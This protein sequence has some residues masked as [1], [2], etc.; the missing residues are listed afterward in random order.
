MRSA[1][2]LKHMRHLFSE[3]V[4]TTGAGDCFVGASLSWIFNHKLCLG[5]Y[6]S[7]ELTDLLI[8]GNTVASLSIQKHG[9]I[10]AMPSL[11]EISAFQAE[12]LN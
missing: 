2:M 4:D 6:T 8:Y 10:A 9:A 5:G 1:E 12:R 11:E 3:V 7:D